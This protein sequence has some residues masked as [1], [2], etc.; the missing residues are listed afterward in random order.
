MKMDVDTFVIANE[1]FD[2][3]PIRVFEASD[4][5]HYALYNPFTVNPQKAPDGWHEVLV[6][7]QDPASS[8][9]RT[10]LL[11]PSSRDPLPSSSSLNR[12]RFVLSHSPVPVPAISTNPRFA[13]LENGTRMEYSWAAVG[14]MR[15]I[16]QLISTDKEGVERAVD[17]DRRKAVHTGGG[18]ALLVDYGADHLFSNSLRV[19]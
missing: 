12:F 11:Q 6:D 9:S 3:L 8:T 13:K 19:R 15:K 10:G 16:A 18:M 4:K 2:A 7:S 17:P 5:C 1:F 14:I